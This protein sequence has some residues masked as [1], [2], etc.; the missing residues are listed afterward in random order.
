MDLPGNLNALISSVAAANPHVVVVMQS[1]NPVSMPWI[2]SV[3]AVVQAWYGGNETGNAIADV[4]FGVTNPSGKLSLTF[5]LRCEDNPAF[6]NYR[7][8]RGRTRYGEDVY[9]GYRFYEKTKK[10]VLFPFGHGL[11]YTT[12]EMKDFILAEV[13]DVL[14]VTVSVTNTGCREGAHVVQ[15][16]V[17]QAAPSINRPVKELKGFNKVFLKAGERKTVEVSIGKK[18]AASFWD[19][20]RDMWI[21]EKDRYEV[22]VGDSSANTPLHRSFEVEN[23]EWWK[24]L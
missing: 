12:F 3:P 20:K 10:E 9:V 6:L 22:L 8:E 19:E 1:G 11:S 21:M 24:G 16:Y 15:V 14:K 4:L 7:S 13:E 17:S 2:S 18:Y 23:T 5:P